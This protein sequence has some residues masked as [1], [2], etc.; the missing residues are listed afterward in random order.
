MPSYR[1][2]LTNG[3]GNVGIHIMMI[4]KSSDTSRSDYINTYY[5][6]YLTNT[7]VSLVEGKVYNIRA[8]ATHNVP[9]PAQ[10]LAEYNL[11]G[12]RQSLSGVAGI[13]E[14]GTLGVFRFSNRDFDGQVWCNASGTEDP[15]LG[16]LNDRSGYYSGHYMFP[17]VA[18]SVFFPNPE[19]LEA[20]I[21]DVDGQI[22]DWNDLYY[23]PDLENWRGVLPDQQSM[24]V[25]DALLKDIKIGPGYDHR[26]SLR[27]RY[28][29]EYSGFIDEVN[30]GVN[31]IV[32][33]GI[34]LAKPL[35]AQEGYTSYLG[36]TQYTLGLWPAYI[37]APD[38][39]FKS[40]YRYR[41]QTHSD[42]LRNRL[43]IEV[44]HLGD[45]GSSPTL[46]AD[47]SSS[48]WWDQRKTDILSRIVPLTGYI[49]RDGYMSYDMDGNQEPYIMSRFD[50]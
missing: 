5:T 25:E 29:A 40:A 34:R 35:A 20:N 43:V 19:P 28:R 33:Y 48:A 38:D 50:A 49:W 27:R 13:P 14:A 3:E 17:T 45:E 41:Y 23:L 4:G 6:D 24:Q 36:Y 2:S 47:I 30:N 21:M 15:E 39:N 10:A 18:D 46:L 44:I 7:G 31:E 11:A 37:S 42:P 9:L 22:R 16:H 12:G 26:Q 32:Q 1:R 8:N